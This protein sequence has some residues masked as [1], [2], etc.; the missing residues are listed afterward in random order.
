MRP[1][2]ANNFA[3][4]SYVTAA[5]HQ[6]ARVPPPEDFTYPHT[7][8][9]PM[10]DII[11][12]IKNQFQ[13]SPPV[14]TPLRYQAMSVHERSSKAKLYF[15]LTDDAEN[16]STNENGPSHYAWGNAIFNCASGKFESWQGNLSMLSS[17][18]PLLKPN[19]ICPAPSIAPEKSWVICVDSAKA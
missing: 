6:A 16:V 7:T 8:I 9:R 14:A 4:L 18:S 12:E 17:D 11:Q 3:A 13:A 15:L 10:A 2:L 5:Y 1:L 19:A